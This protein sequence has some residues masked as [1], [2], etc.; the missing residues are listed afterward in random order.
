MKEV[1]V[2]R[3][4]TDKLLTLSMAFI[5]EKSYDNVIKVL[6]GEYFYIVEHPEGSYSKSLGRFTLINKFDKSLMMLGLF[7]NKCEQYIKFKNQMVEII[8]GYYIFKQHPTDGEFAY[9]KYS[10]WI[11]ER[12]NSKLK[13]L[14]D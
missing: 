9:D 10:Y 11:Q 4:L 3:E 13:Q 12:R 5:S 7:T 2:D 14:I 8:D 6:E 1:K